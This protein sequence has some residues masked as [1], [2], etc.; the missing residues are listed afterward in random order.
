MRLTVLGIVAGIALLAGLGCFIYQRFAGAPSD[1]LVLQGNV[2][3]RQV[4]LG[5][6][7]AG[8]VK[9]MKLEEGDVAHA[10]EVIAILDDVP[11]QYQVKLAAAQLAQAQANYAKMVDGCRPEE[12]E[13]ARAQLAQARA[14]A[15]NASKNFERQDKLLQTHVIS[16]SD[17]D[18]ATSCRDSLKAQLQ[19]AQA[20]LHLELEGNRSEDIANAKAQLE[21]A[22]ANLD[23][24]KQNLADC[25]LIAPV[26]GVIITRALEPGT[27]VSTSSVVYS[28]CQNAPIW[29]RTYVDERDLGRIYPGMKALVYNDTNPDQAYVGQVG[30]ISPIAEFTPKNVETR[31]LRT[32]LVYRLRVILTKPDRYLRR[33]M[34][35]TLQMVDDGHEC[36]QQRN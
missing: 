17:Y 24:A 11:Y 23:S 31:E 28:I 33:G 9:E 6:R 21:N 25:Q 1:K 16:Q 5:F 34:P 7:V 22:Q 36:E 4:N 8:K 27:I 29:V 32:D 20:N 18:N 13:Q 35:V 15:D 2:D 30:F 12:I 3:I 14:N 26:D 19:L 10:G